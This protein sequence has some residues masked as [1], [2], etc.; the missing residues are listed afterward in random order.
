MVCLEAAPALCAPDFRCEILSLNG[1]ATATDKD[2]AKRPLKEGDLLQA[3]EIVE[4]GEGGSLDLSYDRDWNNVVRFEAGSR[5]KVTLIAPGK[6]DLEQG[7]V[8]ARL[9]KLPRDSTFEVS[10]PNAIAAVRGSEYRVVLEAGRTEV[11][12]FSES[13]NVLIYDR[14]PDGSPDLLS[15]VTLPAS[16]ITHLESSG[17]PPS[18]PEGFLEEDAARGSATD[19]EIDTNITEAI[20]HGRR[21]RIQSVTDIENYIK[22]QQKEE[23]K[24]MLLPLRRS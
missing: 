1:Q 8:F 7:S 2:S 20:R 4:V 14:N 3:G 6:I 18:T 23:E 16:A 24:E 15:Q 19:R 5:G 12:N 10:T 9:K 11:F 21:G 17:G 13:S 22:N